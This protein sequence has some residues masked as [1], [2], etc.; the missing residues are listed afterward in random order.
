MLSDSCA[1]FK[2]L[3][4]TA[5]FLDFPQNNLIGQTIGSLY[6]LEELYIGAKAAV[7][8]TKVEIKKEQ[9]VGGIYWE[10]S[11]TEVNKDSL[12]D[13][14]CTIVFVLI[15]SANFVLSLKDNVAQVFAD[16]DTMPPSGLSAE[17]VRPLP[18]RLATN[19]KGT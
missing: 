15:N 12:K 18:S 6:G 2:G 11:T 13:E 8:I 3:I 9:L 10:Q 4:Q 5:G 19:N 1:F 16:L 14:L 7:K 17:R